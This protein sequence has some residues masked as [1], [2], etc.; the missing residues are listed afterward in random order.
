MTR[1]A[2]I[3]SLARTTRG[4]P[5][6]SIAKPP[7]VDTFRRRQSELLNKNFSAWTLIRSKH[8]WGMLRSFKGTWRGHRK[9]E[10][11]PPPSVLLPLH[12]SLV[13]SNNS[14]IPTIGPVEC[15]RFLFC[16][17]GHETAHT[18]AQSWRLL[19]VFYLVLAAW[20]RCNLR[21]ESCLFH[22]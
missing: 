7:L 14:F 12:S 15:G 3:W 8:R 9:A 13:I 21:N 5:G 1:S 16:S 4:T 19:A 6:E 2:L 10:G 22:L 17:A 11:G 18:F 20:L